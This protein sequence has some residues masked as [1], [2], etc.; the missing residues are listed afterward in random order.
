MN[1]QI[2]LKDF[3]NFPHS[4]GSFYSTFTEFCGFKPQS[5]EWKLMGASAY[6]EKSN[7]Y[8]KVK[9]LISY[10]DKKN[11]YLDLNIEGI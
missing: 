11:F 9:N 10:N 2:A 1:N 6:G 4:L 5:E 7:L 8:K 3:Q